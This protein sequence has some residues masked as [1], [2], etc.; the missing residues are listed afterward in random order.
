MTIEELKEMQE[1][2]VSK[3]Y[4]EVSIPTIRFY[5]LKVYGEPLNESCSAC[6]RDSYVRLKKWYHAQI[7]KV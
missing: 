5:H 1:K 6:I 2:L 4:Y 3:S 7:E